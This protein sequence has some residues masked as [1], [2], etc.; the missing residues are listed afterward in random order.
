MVEKYPREEIHYK[1]LYKKL[2]IDRKLGISWPESE[3]E[4][5]TSA[6]LVVDESLN[7]EIQGSSR[8]LCEYDES[9]CLENQID[10]KYFANIIEDLEQKLEAVIYEKLDLVK[11]SE[12]QYNKESNLTKSLIDEI[13]PSCDICGHDDNDENSRIVYCHGCGISVHAE[14]YGIV[15]VPDFWFCSKCIFSNYDECC[16]LCGKKEGIFKMSDDG[17]WAHALCAILNKKL[18]FSNDIHKEPVDTSMLSQNL[19]SKDECC[20][21]CGQHAGCLITCCYSTCKEKYHAS[22]AAER[23][24]CDL[25]NKN[26][27]CTAHSIKTDRV[28]VLSRRNLLKT[29]A[30]YPEIE[31]EPFIRKN[32][33]MQPPQATEFR[34]AVETSPSAITC[35]RKDKTALKIRKYW[36]QKK[37]AYGTYYENIFKYTNYMNK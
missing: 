12:K 36:I 4:E 21:I 22:C 23:F 30:S 27:Y 17:Q 16:F 37:T 26:T 1:K 2:D 15:V 34:K 18:S 35:L 29:R 24:Y 9:F 8:Y 28:R 32:A 19:N 14:C 33:S 31:N 11:N 10:K 5:S 3:K 20:S 25:N 13:T 7:Y 6:C